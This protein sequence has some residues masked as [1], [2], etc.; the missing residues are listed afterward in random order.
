MAQ[1]TEQQSLSLYPKGYSSKKFK[2][3]VDSV[4]IYNI[5]KEAV[6]FAAA[7]A[8]VTGFGDY[9]QKIGRELSQH[10]RYED[11]N[12]PGEMTNIGS[13]WDGSKVGK[14]NEVDS[15]YVM[16]SGPFIIKPTAKPG[17]YQ[18]ITQIESQE[19]E[20]KPRKLRNQFADKYSQLISKMG[21]PNCLSHGGYN[22][23]RWP[24]QMSA[25]SDLRYNGPAATSQFLTDGKSLLTWDVTPCIEFADSKI[26]TEVREIIGP[27]IS[28]NP[29]KQFPQIPVHLIPDPLEDL[30]R[31]STA[32][33]EAELLRF[34]SDSAPV[35]KAL[36]LCKILCSLLQKW[37]QRNQEQTAHTSQGIAVVRKLIRHLES[38]NPENE[39][40][41]RIMR[42]AHIWLPSDK[43]AEY[44]EDEKSKISINT[45]AVKHIIL[46][47][48]L[49]EEGAFAPAQNEDLVLK[50]VKVVFQ[51]LSNYED[52]ASDHVFLFGT[53]ICHFSVLG[54]YQGDK[55]NLARNICEQCR[56]LLSGAM[57]EVGICSNHN[58]ANTHVLIYTDQLDT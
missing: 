32:H 17:F 52:F 46:R 20:I 31:V 49:K 41:E 9:R 28:Q 37:N 27:I 24:G 48:G 23:S 22:S 54:G 45:A 58:K 11:I 1:L 47:E 57:S 19:Y 36:M 7:D 55:V 43:R 29:T 8:I 2:E 10:F 16:N 5:E 14:V 33:F 18:V 50:L 13:C 34:L 51:A 35:K 38:G 53:R 6:N 12:L 42:F 4:D 56:I 21:L 30:W 3:W 25:F 44:N 39:D 26:Q 40:L 15:L